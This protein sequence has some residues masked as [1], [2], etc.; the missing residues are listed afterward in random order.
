MKGKLT[1]V[2]CAMA[3]ICVMACNKFFPNNDN[4]L[5]Q[6]DR[7]FMTQASYANNSEVAAGQVATTKG[8]DSSVKAF[9]AFMV[10]EHSTAQNELQAIADSITLPDTPDSVHM[11]LLQKLQTLSGHTFDTAYIQSQ[12][13]DHNMAIVLFK[14]EADYGENKKL[15]DYAAKNLPHL[16]MHLEMADSVWA[17]IQ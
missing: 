3:A 14:Q 1:G 8:M 2:T 9:G 5:S 6:L 11:M 15:R 16:R 4:N 17:K 7:S 13:K 12:I 10:S